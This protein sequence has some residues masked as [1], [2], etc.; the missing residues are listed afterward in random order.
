MKPEYCVDLNLVVA[1]ARKQR[2]EKMNELLLRLVN[3]IRRPFR[4]GSSRE[5]IVK[6]ISA[7]SFD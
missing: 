3:R 4:L 6:H 5:R 2:A 1:H 7:H